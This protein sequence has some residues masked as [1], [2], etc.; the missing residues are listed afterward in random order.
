[1]PCW[2]PMHHLHFLSF[3]STSRKLRQSCN[4]ENLLSH[5]NRWKKWNLMPSI[6]IKIKACSNLTG[7]RLI[8]TCSEAQQGSN[9]EA[10]TCR[11]MIIIQW[12]YGIQVMPDMSPWSIYH[13]EATW[14]DALKCI[15]GTENICVLSQLSEQ[16]QT[17]CALYS[18]CTVPVC[19][20]N[21]VP[22]RRS[23]HSPFT[24][25]S[26]NFRILSRITLYPNCNDTLR[27]INT[28]WCA[29]LTYQSI[30]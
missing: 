16:K 12:I 28:I 4:P 29:R 2:I 15:L 23:P 10:T 1:M 6:D 20:V 25:V 3:S 18:W 7:E 24:F 13:T 5:M 19:K 9:N 11:F 14:E 8:I 30:F 22:R 21:A 26:S 27:I 17:T